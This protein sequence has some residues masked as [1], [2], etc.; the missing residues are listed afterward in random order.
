M[1]KGSSSNVE[2]KRYLLVRISILEH[3]QIKSPSSSKSSSWV[4]TSN[5]CKRQPWHSIYQH[6]AQLLQERTPDPPLSQPYV[7]NLTPKKKN[8]TQQVYLQQ[9]RCSCIFVSP[10]PCFRIRRPSQLHAGARAL[11]RRTGSLRIKASNPERPQ[12][13]PELLWWEG[14]RARAARL[15]GASF[16]FP[17]M[18][19]TTKRSM[20]A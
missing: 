7:K 13:G 4:T 15:L 18:P 11:W 14:S 19:R 9:P 16:S 20:S 5:S 10:S 17:T 6:H 1:G 8:I 3:Y 2:R 12:R